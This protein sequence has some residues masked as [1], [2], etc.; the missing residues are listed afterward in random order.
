MGI[1]RVNLENKL[2]EFSLTCFRLQPAALE[3]KTMKGSLCT[4]AFVSLVQC[5]EQ[6]SIIESTPRFSV[7]AWYHLKHIKAMS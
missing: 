6:T 3:G 4:C 2:S 5:V 7:E 1:K